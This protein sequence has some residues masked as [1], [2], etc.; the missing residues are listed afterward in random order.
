MR[1]N[2]QQLLPNA[3]HSFVH[4]TWGAAGL[5]N[6]SC[7]FGSSCK[8]HRAQRPC[9]MHL[10]LLGVAVCGIGRSGLSTSSKLPENYRILL[11]GQGP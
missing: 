7:F 4:A 10:T 6:A 1:H 8:R 3:S 5:S 2:V 11:R 9:Q